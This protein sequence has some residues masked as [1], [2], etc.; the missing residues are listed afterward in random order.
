MIELDRKFLDDQEREGAPEG[1]EGEDNEESSSSDQSARESESGGLK[2]ENGEDA[3]SKVEAVEIRKK[4]DQDP[5]DYILSLKEESHEDNSIKK[6]R[7]QF[8]VEDFYEPMKAK[9]EV[10]PAFMDRNR[11]LAKEERKG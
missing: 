6:K 1:E 3:I 9:N 8:R 2:L 10:S 5:F 11:T 7:T 4:Q